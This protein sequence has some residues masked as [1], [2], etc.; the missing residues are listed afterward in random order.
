MT[1]ES[2][3]YVCAH[4]YE[5]V[6]EAIRPE[7]HS[8]SDHHWRFA[9]GNSP[10][11]AAGCGVSESQTRAANQGTRHAPPRVDDLGRKAIVSLFGIDSVGMLHGVSTDTVWSS[12]NRRQ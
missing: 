6:G 10:N 7:E 3:H 12:A 9:V 5:E 1:Y 2:H 11:V 8:I 4:L